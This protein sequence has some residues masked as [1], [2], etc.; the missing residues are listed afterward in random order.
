MILALWVLCWA[1]RITSEEEIKLERAGTVIA[2]KAIELRQ[3]QTVLRAA[4]KYY[5][6]F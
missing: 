1:A 5:L 4:G 3:A 6:P 2:G